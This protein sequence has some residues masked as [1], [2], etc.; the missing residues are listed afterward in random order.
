[1]LC[2]L[3]CAMASRLDAIATIYLVNIARCYVLHMHAPRMH[4]LRMYAFLM[5]SIDVAIMYIN[6]ATT[7]SICWK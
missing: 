1:M 6:R 3:L 5:Y 4:A 2:P 7:Q